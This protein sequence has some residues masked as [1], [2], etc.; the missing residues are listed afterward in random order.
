MDFCSSTTFVMAAVRAVSRVHSVPL[1]FLSLHVVSL[2]TG[3]NEYTY[4]VLRY[5]YVYIFAGL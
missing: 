4:V 5:M 1:S 2:F 3:T